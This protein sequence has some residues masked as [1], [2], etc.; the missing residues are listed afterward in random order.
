MFTNLC[1]HF[2]WCLGLG[3]VD[4]NRKWVSNLEADQGRG[5]APVGVAHDPAGLEGLHLAQVDLH[6]VDLLGDGDVDV[7][8]PQILVQPKHGVA[9]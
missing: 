6:G 2:T 7:G 1:L 4:E 3:V 8:V 9:N 5:S